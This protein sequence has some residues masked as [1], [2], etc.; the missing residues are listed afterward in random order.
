ME[1][2]AMSP[3][4]RSPALPIH[5]FIKNFSLTTEK[6]YSFK[7]I[8]SKAIEKLPHEEKVVLSLYLCEEM[9]VAEIEKI[10]GKTERDIFQ[11]FLSAISNLRCKIYSCV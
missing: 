11:V 2:N 10:L 8:L 6:I 5:D 9:T 1:I 7:N 3:Q 4:G